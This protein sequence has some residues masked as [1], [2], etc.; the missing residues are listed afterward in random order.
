MLA[1]L[2]II[3]KFIRAL[4][5]SRRWRTVYHDMQR[6][7]AEKPIVTHCPHSASS[8]RRITDRRLSALVRSLPMLPRRRVL[9]RPT[10]SGIYM[11][12]KKA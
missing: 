2:C 1:P 9:P 3:E 7:C 11:A 10:A 5:V 12:D 4:V 8:S 6:V